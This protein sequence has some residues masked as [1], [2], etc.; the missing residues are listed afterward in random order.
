MG[1]STANALASTPA[2]KKAMTRTMEKLR[3]MQPRLSKRDFFR[4]STRKCAFTRK[5]RPAAGSLRGNCRPGSKPAERRSA[6]SEATSAA[7]ASPSASLRS[8]RTEMLKF[9][10]R[11]GNDAPRRRRRLFLSSRNFIGLRLIEFFDGCRS[12]RSRSIRQRRFAPMVTAIA[13]EWV[14]AINSESVTAFIVIR[15]LIGPGEV[16]L[17]F[18][19]FKNN[20]VPRISETFNAQFRAEFFNILNHANL[21]V[22]VTPDNTDIFD[23]TGARTGVAG[24]LTSTTTTAREIQLALKISW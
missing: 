23:S 12:L 17:D 19:V 13:S 1:E 6:G 15:I 10:L 20:R 5:I 3:E 14:T 16:N 7:V 22:P 2:P 8:V 4:A 21:S 9:P 11:G 24:L 18:S